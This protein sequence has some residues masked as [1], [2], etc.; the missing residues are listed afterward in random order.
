MQITSKI[1][2]IW[3]QVNSSGKEIQMVS[4]QETYTLPA[5]YLIE[6]NVGYSLLISAHYQS[7]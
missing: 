3:R 5:D 4:L 2:F 7:G 6:K 1:Y